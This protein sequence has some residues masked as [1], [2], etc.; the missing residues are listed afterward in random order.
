M[1]L[2]SINRKFVHLLKIL[3][4][5]TKGSETLMLRCLYKFRTVFFSNELKI[6]ILQALFELHHPHVQNT[7]RHSMLLT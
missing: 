3:Q 7:I 2:E 4:S 1:I 6:I 5:I